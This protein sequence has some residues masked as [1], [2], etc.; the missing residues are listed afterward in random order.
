M[1]DRLIGQEYH[2]ILDGYSGYNQ[3]IV[4]PEDQEKTTITCPYG[5][6]A[7]KRMPFGLCNAPVTFQRCMTTIFTAVMEQFMEVFMMTSLFSGLHL[8]TT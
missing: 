2:G 8:M 3:I 1:L 5:I 6:Y 4:A 7:F